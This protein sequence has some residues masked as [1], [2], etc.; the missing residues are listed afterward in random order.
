MQITNRG[1]VKAFITQHNSNYRKKMK[2]IFWIV[3]LLGTFLYGGSCLK[4]QYNG[5]QVLQIIPQTAKHAEYL[6]ELA[7]NWP[8][9]L[10]RPNIPEG[11]Q[12]GREVHIHIPSSHV[13]EMKNVLLQ[14]DIPYSVLIE[15][16][17]QSIDMNMVHN[18]N[19]KAVSLN[20]YDYTQYHPMHEIYDWM[21][22]IKENHNDLVTKLYLGETYEKRPIYYFR[23]GW[24]SEK[25][26]KIMFIDCGFHAREWVSVAFCQWFVKELVSSHKSDAI[27][28]KVLKEVD[29]YIVPVFNIDGYIYTWTTERLWRKN[30]APFNNGTCYGVDLNR[31]FDAQW[32][33]IGA[34]KNCSSN[35]FCGPS[36][37]S[38][39]ETKALAGLIERIKSDILFYL[40]IHSYGKMIL[41]PYGYKD[42]VSKDHDL[43]MKVATKAN[44]QMKV[45]NN[46]EYAAG[47]SA[48]VIGYYDSGSSG[49]WATDIGIKF[50]YTFELRDNGTHGF[51]LPQDQI[52]PTCEEVTTAILSMVEYVHDNYLENSGVAL[53]AVWI[54]MFISVICLYYTINL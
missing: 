25:K 44:E 2:L 9:D 45:K 50:S 38:E 39:P 34:S 47:A 48:S 13:N 36:A 12:A 40:T 32:C 21:E 15:D 19:M 24:P 18:K 17:Q 29:F 6:Q 22:Q 10:W 41:L 8:L 4:V 5:D 14:Y 52:K 11:I 42:E 43:M 16:V 28:A 51:Q 53:T 30:R 27:L 54:N 23:V 1:L 49:D 31:N 7:N 35:T 37:A 20:T 26:K 33:T 46:N 3:C